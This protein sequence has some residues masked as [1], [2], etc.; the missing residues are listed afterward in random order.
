MD[1]NCLRQFKVAGMKFWLGATQVI[2]RRFQPCAP[3]LAVSGDKR[4]SV[5]LGGHDDFA[6]ATAQ[7]KRRRRA[8][9]RFLGRLLALIL[10]KS[11]FACS[12][13]R[14]GYHVG[15]GADRLAEAVHQLIPLVVIA[16]IAAGISQQH[17]T[18]R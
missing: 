15:T 4:G 11:S 14:Q 5:I 10:D 16:P 9:Y 8:F 18:R 3:P 6:V 7:D 12:G 1:E 17:G 2:K 13:R